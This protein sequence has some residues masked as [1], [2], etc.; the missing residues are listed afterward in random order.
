MIKKCLTFWRDK[1]K[2]LRK[3]SD[4]RL[5]DKNSSEPLKK[6]KKP[7]KA[8]KR[9]RWTFENHGKKNEKR[10]IYAII[11]WKSKPEKNDEK[12]KKNP[13]KKKQKNKIY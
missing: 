6:V 5:R 8:I 9:K 10:I 11:G 13:M 7:K 2:A 1:L 3:K 4:H 12:K